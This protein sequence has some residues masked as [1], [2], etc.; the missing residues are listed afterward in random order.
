VIRP[1]AADPNETGPYSTPA[2]AGDGTRPGTRTAK[3]FPFLKE[4]SVRG[5]L[6]QLGPYRVVCVLREGGMGVVFRGYDPRVPRPVAVK[7]LRPGSADSFQERM[8]GE[9]M[10]AGRLE[11]PNTVPVY[12]CGEQGGAAFLVM[13]LL[14]GEALDERLA[15]AAPLPPA[16]VRRVARDAAAGLAAAHAAG[17]VHRDLK[18]SNLWV[19][20]DPAGGW[21]VRVFDF[22]LALTGDGSGRLTPAGALVGTPEYMSPEQA[23]GAPVDERADLFSLGVVLYQAATGVRPFAAGN[24]VATARAVADVDPDPPAVVRPDV[25]ADLSALV[26][27]LLAKD[28]AARPPS[29][30]AVLADLGVE[31]PAPPARARRGAWWAAAAVAVA[32]GLVAAVLAN[33]PWDWAAPTPGGDGPP[34]GPPFPRPRAG[35]MR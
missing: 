26:M 9:I 24:V 29:A 11:H 1:H 35:W 27:R 30:R 34:P 12:D 10:A 18:P 28:P 4:P 22:G 31:P 15:R 33:R 7:V 2:A 16:D 14:R 3:D 5:D 23:T 25:P 21:R 20:D 8:R 32:A 19:E 17:V 13:P 6:G